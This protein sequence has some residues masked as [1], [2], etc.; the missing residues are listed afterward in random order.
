MPVP[1]LRGEWTFR[2]HGTSRASPHSLAPRATSGTNL[3]SD[4]RR[5]D[6]SGASTP[7]RRRPWPESMNVGCN[8]DGRRGIR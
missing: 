3:P 1:S 4:P 6:S 5:L 8:G 7:E 2:R